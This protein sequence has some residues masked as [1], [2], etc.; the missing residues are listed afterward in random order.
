MKPFLLLATRADDTAADEE[1]AAFARFG[2][3]E[4]DQLRR[5]RL[6]AGPMPAI[7]LNDY[8]GI[9]LGGSPF[10]SS[11]DDATKPAVQ[12]R[13]EAELEQLLDTVVARDFPFL[14]ACYG[15]GTLGRH[16]GGVV[17]RQYG[18]P[19]GAAQVVLTDDG[20]ADPLLSGLP[21]EFSAFVGHKEACSVLPAGAVHLAKS[22]HCP[23]QMFRLQNNLYAT[24][25][26][27][28]LDT[29]GLLTRIWIY[30]DAGY[31]PPDQAEAVMEQVRN[32]TVSVPQ[33]ILR[34]FVAR[35]ATT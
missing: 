33:R 20:A 27:A 15:V 16:R 7:N 35:Y 18:E 17:D 26:H 21:R 1:Y 5:V 11:D 25:F 2:G 22:E 34:N 32:R 29:E 8:S 31:F 30:R 3:L 24:Q 12:L 28:E 19:I 4:P 13:V 23:Y 6:E 10:T 14:G 9:I